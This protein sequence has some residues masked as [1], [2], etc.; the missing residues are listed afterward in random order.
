MTLRRLIRE[1][2]ARLYSSLAMGPALGSMLFLSAI[3]F[4]FEGA[5]ASL[6]AFGA[7]VLA[8]STSYLVG[9]LTREE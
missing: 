7:Y 6:L 8:T 1:L 4:Y 2:N 9:Y 3:L 5:Y